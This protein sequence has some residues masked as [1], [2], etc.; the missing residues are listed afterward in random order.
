MDCDSARHTNAIHCPESTLLAAKTYEKERGETVAAVQRAS[1]PV[2][3]I[4]QELRG[5]AAW[6]CLPQRVSRTRGDLIGKPW[7][8]R[9]RESVRIT[10]RIVRG[11]TQR[12][13]LG[14]ITSKSMAFQQ[15][16]Q[17]RAIDAREPR[18]A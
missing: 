2:P 11:L 17:R 6:Q 7:E 13:R 18:R 16:I 14:E 10:G 8:A 4:E 5:K 15:A 1:G 9:K 3:Q 12:C